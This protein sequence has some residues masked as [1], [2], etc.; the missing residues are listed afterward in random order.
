[1]AIHL[2]SDIVL[3]VARAADPETVRA[4][5]ARLTRLGATKAVAD[6]GFS[7][8]V[9]GMQT[10]APAPR[11]AEGLAAREI[12]S[13]SVRPARRSPAQVYQAFEALIFENLIEM[14]LPQHA[15]EIFGH[16]TAGEVW[17]SMLAQQLGV[18]VA[19]ADRSGILSRLFAS[20]VA[21]AERTNDGAS[22]ASGSVDVSIGRARS[23]GRRG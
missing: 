1:M 23:S 2:P 14:M 8:I 13:Q 6:F 10:P 3:D 5:S 17:K 4:A 9:D 12:G 15:A 19:K 16:G 20:S 7:Q 11:Q 18:E 22:H 21:N